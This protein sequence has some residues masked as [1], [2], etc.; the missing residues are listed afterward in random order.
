MSED[1]RLI[2][3]SKQKNKLQGWLNEFEDQNAL[4]LAILALSHN[5]L[6]EF[7]NGIVDAHS[8]SSKEYVTGTDILKLAVKILRNEI[9]RIENIIAHDNDSVMQ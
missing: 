7:Y 4:D 6:S 8:S 9:V 3:I 1:E 5:F 2:R